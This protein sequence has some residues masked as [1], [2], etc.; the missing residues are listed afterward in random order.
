MLGQRP[1]GNVKAYAHELANNTAQ[2]TILIALPN[3]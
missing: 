1:F 3:L 2:L